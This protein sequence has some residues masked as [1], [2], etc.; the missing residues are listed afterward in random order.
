MQM[1]RDS[2]KPFAVQLFAIRK[3]IGAAPV[4]P[5]SVEDRAEELAN[6]TLAYRHLED[7]IMRCGKVIQAYNGGVNPNEKPATG[8]VSTPGGQIAG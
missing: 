8:G 2:L 4:D 1:M 7:A 6:L 3:Q 5:K